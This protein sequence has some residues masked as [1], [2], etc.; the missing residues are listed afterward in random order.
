MA[1]ARYMEFVLIL[2]T[3]KNILRDHLRSFRLPVFRCL[4]HRLI[5][6]NI[7]L[8]PAL[9]E[10]RCNV[11]KQLMDNSRRMLMSVLFG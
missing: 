10:T 3:I 4:R 1:L 7:S 11:L 6:R 2:E 9:G 8:V 5:P